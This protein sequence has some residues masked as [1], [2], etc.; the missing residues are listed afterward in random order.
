M[1][2]AHFNKAKQSQPRQW[3]RSYQGKGS[4]FLMH[5]MW[6]PNKSET[7]ALG[8]RDCIWIA[9]LGRMCPFSSQ[10][11]QLTALKRQRKL[12]AIWPTLQLKLTPALSSESEKAARQT[13]LPLHVPFRRATESLQPL[14][15]F[16]G[17]TWTPSS[18]SG[19]LACQ[20]NH[21]PE[22]TLIRFLQGSNHCIKLQGFLL[23]L[24]FKY[25]YILKVP[26]DILS[27]LSA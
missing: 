26:F 17:G 4:G 13:K 5:V 27:C 23:G 8:G 7:G 25:K 21:S 16:P 3:Y 6:K 18:T 1:H 19:Q 12:S 10:V 14:L 11:S 2:G 15:F 24:M 9:T 20:A 22:D